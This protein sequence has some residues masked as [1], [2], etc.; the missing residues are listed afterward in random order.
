VG[1][2]KITSSFSVALCFVT[3]S[4]FVGINAAFSTSLR[5]GGQVFIW[6]IVSYLNVLLSQCFP[7]HD[8]EL[9]HL[10]SSL[11]PCMLASLSQMIV[12][13][14]MKFVNLSALG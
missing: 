6:W 9:I 14:K 11:A 5:E 12:K 10:Q 7:K 2:Q 3:H 8:D 1:K 4:L 13:S